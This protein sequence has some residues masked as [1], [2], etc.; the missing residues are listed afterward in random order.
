LKTLEMGILEQSAYLREQGSEETDDVRD[1]RSSV[2]K[3]IWSGVRNAFRGRLP[4]GRTV[5]MGVRSLLLSAVQALRRGI[6]WITG[7][8]TDMAG[9]AL[10][11]ARTIF[12]RVHEAVSLFIESAPRALHFIFRRPVVT[13]DGSGVI[14]SRFDL[15][16]DVITFVSTGAS[17]AL[18]TRHSRI[19][20]AL[21]ADAGLW[22]SVAAVTART[23]VDMGTGVGWLRL[24]F[25]IGSL[26]REI[27]AS[28][29]QSPA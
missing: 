17:D 2:F 25:R 19:C 28:L 15:D 12:I 20:R 14:V 18:I 27:A 13:H 22:L 10:S 21:A 7:A 1:T 6:N 4:S 16:A 3:T 11:L 23:V 8:L 9:S 29:H 5:Y 24:G 26:A